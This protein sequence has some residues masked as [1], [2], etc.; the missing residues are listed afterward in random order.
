MKVKAIRQI[1]DYD[2]DNRQT[3]VLNIGDTGDLSENMLAKH[4]GSWEPCEAR[5]EAKSK[6][7]KQAGAEA[8]SPFTMT[9]KGFGKY[10]IEGPGIAPDTIIKGKA[11]AATFI[12]QVEKSHA[13]KLIEPRELAEGETLEEGEGGPGGE[14][15]D[16]PIFDDAAPI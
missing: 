5:K 7:G 9:H 10:L 12:A 3:V 1:I 6:G 11:D 13:E 2:A 14:S 15:I 16:A 4:E 8:S